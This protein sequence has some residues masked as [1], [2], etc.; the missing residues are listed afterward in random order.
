MI[1]QLAE[2][3]VCKC[4]NEDVINRKSKEI[5]YY[6]LSRIVFFII[7]LSI[8]GI[9]S[10]LINKF[11]ISM[12]YCIV[13]I[14]LSQYT[15]SYH[16]KTR[17]LCSIK[18]IFVYLCYIVVNSLIITKINFLLEILFGI[19]FFVFLK[20]A[21]IKNKNNVFSP[22]KVRKKK[23]KGLTLSVLYFL[24]SIT[25]YSANNNI[26]V[27]YSYAICFSMTFTIILMLIGYL[28]NKK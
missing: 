19:Y 17:L 23:I 27:Q 1:D 21:P 20:L 9:I 15:G 11:A 18:T 22:E 7:N 28:L 13:F 12:V 24:V 14:S 4:V 2:K 5:I 6:G 16:A 8:I 3:L 25:I 10:L 26:L